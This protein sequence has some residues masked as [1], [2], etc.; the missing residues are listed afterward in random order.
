MTKCGF[1]ISKLFRWTLTHLVLLLPLLIAAWRIC[2]V[3]SHLVM[4]QILIR[5]SV[6]FWNEREKKIQFNKEFH[7]ELLIENLQKLWSTL[8]R[9]WNEVTCHIKVVIHI[10]A[11][12]SIVF[13]SNYYSTTIF[14]KSAIKNYRIVIQDVKFTSISITQIEVF[15]I[16]LLTFFEMN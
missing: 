6:T 15:F 14:K 11:H 4:P 16:T 13:F 9:W 7:L 10:T 8:V 12:Q 5:F 3:I 1:K 2:I